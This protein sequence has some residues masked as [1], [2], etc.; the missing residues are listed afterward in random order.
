MFLDNTE[1]RVV[2]SYERNAAK[3]TYTVRKRNRLKITFSTSTV[4]LYRFIGPSRKLKIK[5]KK[6]SYT[7]Y[8]NVG[9]IRK[10]N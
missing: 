10:R 2:K 3:I 5:K 1:R 9:R 7:N 6:N 8:D 4:K